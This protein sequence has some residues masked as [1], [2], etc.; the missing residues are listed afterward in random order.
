[1]G[2]LH[3]I[4]S[5]CLT[6]WKNARLLPQWLN[7]LASPPNMCESSY[8]SVSS[9]SA[10]FLVAILIALWWYLI[11]FHQW[12]MIMRSNHVCSYA[13]LPSGK[14]LWLNVCSGLLPILWSVGCFLT[15]EHGEFFMCSRH[16]PFVRQDFLKH[17][18]CLFILWIM[19]F[20]EQCVSFWWGPLFLSFF[21]GVCFCCLI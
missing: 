7:H 1:M 8:T 16:Q 21:A 20:T 15:V 18:A 13:S 2:L 6:L 19:S 4:I 12:L 11:T 9:P 17:A 5:A 10:L 14:P 3:H